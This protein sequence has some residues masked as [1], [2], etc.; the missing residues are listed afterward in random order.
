MQAD[1]QS[2]INGHLRPIKYVAQRSVRDT[3]QALNFLQ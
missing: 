2:S 1:K 3:K